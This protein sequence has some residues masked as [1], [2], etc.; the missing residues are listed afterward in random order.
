[1]K[2][3]TI[4]MAHCSDATSLLSIYAHYVE[5]TA[6]T[7]EYDV[8]TV[9]EF[10]RRIDSTLKKYPYLVA[11]TDGEIVGY[12]YASPFHTRPTYQWNVE[13][14]IYVRA[15][16]NGRGIGRRLYERLEEMLVAQNILNMNACIAYPA[17]EDE[18]LTKASVCFHEKLGFRLVGMFH[19]SGY[20]FGRWYN[21]VWMEKI[22]GEHSEKPSPV[23]ACSSGTGD[24]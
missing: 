8:P 24:V 11:V 2:E 18:F 12:A 6:I 19:Q 17:E 10:R 23:V 21:M 4:R 15:G 22:I 16:W 20:K 5:K 13:V 3:I 7:F 9:E 14:S 1:M